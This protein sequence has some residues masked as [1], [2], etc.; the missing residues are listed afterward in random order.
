MPTVNK[1]AIQNKRN[2]TKCIKMHSNTIFGL[3][4][5]FNFHIMKVGLHMRSLNYNHAVTRSEGN[6]HGNI[7]KNN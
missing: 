1:L 6:Y 3:E 5:V 4:K 2:K 7:N